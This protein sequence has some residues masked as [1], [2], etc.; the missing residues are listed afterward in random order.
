MLMASYCFV[1]YP[2][3]VFIYTIDN[4]LDGGVD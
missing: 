2:I 3:S 1:A 4:E